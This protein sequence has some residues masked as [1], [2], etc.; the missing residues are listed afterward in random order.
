MSYIKAKYSLLEGFKSIAESML[1]F[2]DRTTYRISV[3]DYHTEK[4]LME[5]TWVRVGQDIEEAAEEFGEKY[6]REQ[7]KKIKSHI[8]RICTSAR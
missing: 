2:R 4:S 7:P 3:R 8:R 1:S 5:A 6:G